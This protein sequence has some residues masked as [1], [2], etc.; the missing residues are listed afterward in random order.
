M[1]K[2]HKDTWL[3]DLKK[4]R[5]ELE[6]ELRHLNA[7]KTDL[8]ERIKVL[9]KFVDNQEGLM[10]MQPGLAAVHGTLAKEGRSELREKKRDLSDKQK[11]YQMKGQRLEF[12][13]VLTSYIIDKE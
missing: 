5:E 10:T 8:D 1:K 3:N 4:E 2:P 9:E 11:E 6:E 12:I 7:A 13:K